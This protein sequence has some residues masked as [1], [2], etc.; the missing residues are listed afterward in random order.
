[1]IFFWC[2][3]LPAFYQAANVPQVAQVQCRRDY[4]QIPWPIVTRANA[5][6][7]YSEEVLK[8]YAPFA[9]GVLANIAP[10]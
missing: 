2:N 4:Y 1:M 7:V 10:S 6:G 8:V 3:N 5:T 9:L